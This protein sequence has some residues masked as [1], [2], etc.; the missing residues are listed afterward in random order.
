[1]GRHRFARQ[2]GSDDASGGDAAPGMRRRGPGRCWRS[3]RADRPRRWTGRRLTAVSRPRPRPPNRRSLRRQPCDGP[4]RAV[5]MAGEGAQRAGVGE[6]GAMARVQHGAGAKSSTSRNGA[7]ARAA[8]RRAATSAAKPRPSAGRAQRRLPRR[9]GTW[10]QAESH[11]LWRTSTGRTSTPWRRVP[12]P[13]GW[14]SRSRAA[15]HSAARR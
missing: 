6:Q 3:R 12:A 8:T 15:V 7:T 1:M 5:A 14:P 13:A 4:A 2:L 11:A 10:F 9:I